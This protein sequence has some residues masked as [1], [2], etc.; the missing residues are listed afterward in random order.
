MDPVAE[1]AAAPAEEG[2]ATVAAGGVN[3]D[4]M[5]D[6]EPVR[7]RD[8]EAPS[9]PPPGGENLPV[10]VA[11][12]GALPGAAAPVAQATP[13]GPPKLGKK[14]LLIVPLAVVV[15]LGIYALALKA[16]GGSMAVR[17]SS[18]SRWFWNMS[19]TTPAWS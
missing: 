8:D 17:V 13:S 4:E 9:A 7:F 3:F 1:E 15:I 16:G 5:A 10:A 2:G 6:A 19:R 18:C 14:A 11:P 12:G